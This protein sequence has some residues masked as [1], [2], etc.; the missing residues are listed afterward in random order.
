MEGEK[1][2]SIKIKIPTLPKISTEVFRTNPWIL[3]TIV[4]AL[5]VFMY[6]FS[7]FNGITGNVISSTEAED[8]VLEFL[9][10]QSISDVEIIGIEYL[11]SGFYQVQLSV[12]GQLAELYITRDGKN[13]VQGIIPVSEFF[14]DN[15]DNK[16]NG[17]EEISEL[18][19]VVDSTFKDTGD[20][21]CST[22]EGKPYVILFSTTWCPHCT[23]IKDTFDSL[24]DE[25]FAKDVS[26]QHWE[27]DTG[28]NT[29]T[30][31][32]ETEVPSDL[33]KLYNNYNPEGSIPTYVFGCKYYRQ[34]NG[35]ESQD[36]LEAELEDFKLIIN[37][38]IE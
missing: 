15:E 29:L 9:N 2:D 28:D 24:I 22:D 21:V 27:L 23:W 26:L 19:D 13:I 30:S 34:G 17:N 4:L 11:E 35:Y 12:G 16:N 5:L 32:I 31:E 10:S 7:S 8:I 37:K 18:I 25:N 33:L 3:S 20:E 6:L 14:A 36:D 1:S 38:L